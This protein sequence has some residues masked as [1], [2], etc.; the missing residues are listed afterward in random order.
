M[1][2]YNS[3]LSHKYIKSNSKSEWKEI[4]NVVV[5]YVNEYNINQ[6]DEMLNKIKLCLI[7]IV[8]CIIMDEKYYYK[9]E[10]DKI[11]DCALH[12]P[13]CNSSIN[14]NNNSFR[15]TNFCSSYYTNVKGYEDMNIVNCKIVWSKI[16]SKLSKVYIQ[17]EKNRYEERML[18]KV[19]KNWCD[20]KKKKI[21]KPVGKPTAMDVEIPDLD[22]FEPFLNHLQMNKDVE[23]YK[24]YTKG[25]IFKDGRMDLCKQVVGS[26]WI[27]HLMDSLKENTIISHF[28]LGNNIINNEGSIA[29]KKFLLHHHKP[30]I[31]TWYLAGSDF[32]SES[33][34][35]LCDGFKNDTDIESL[36]LKRNPI[37]AEGMKYIGEL[38]KHNTTIK[39][40]DLHNTGI[41]LY[42]NAYNE[43]NDNY[44]MYTTNE[45]IMYLFDGLK[46][47]NTL[48]HL[49]IDANGLKKDSAEI[50]ANYFDY[51]VNTNEKGITSLWIDMNEFEN[52]GISKIVKSLKDYKY[53]KRLNI[54]SNM[55]NHIGMK[56]ICDA[57]KHHETLEVLDVSLYKSTYDMGVLPNNIGND[58]VRFICEL[59]ET[60]KSLRYLNISMNNI[61]KYFEEIKDALEKNTT[62]WYFV[63]K[64]YGIKFSN[65]YN[66]EI[67]DILIRNQTI[68]SDIVFND[69]HR[70][71]LKYSTLIDNIESIYR[72]KM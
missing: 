32:N 67:N 39:I 2:K 24:E 50:I 71:Y 9:G 10:Y 22:E 20:M 49:Y 33:I 46:Y 29:I 54:G 64:Q 14:K 42:E 69:K 28:L 53:I 40:L 60:N 66:K 62:L 52:S 35:E 17:E 12:A 57:L 37:Y 11:S 47:N 56:F 16:I 44:D 41:G 18:N 31:K 68:S 70:R 19:R 3:L 59:I 65:E 30:Q 23:E 72:N 8:K 51:K 27:N 45:G 6:T 21:M 36:W 58:G 13:R 34:K 26:K 7:K 43:E 1:N 15:P 4:M 38:L 48:E 5:N 61:S 25:T 63:Y 55:I